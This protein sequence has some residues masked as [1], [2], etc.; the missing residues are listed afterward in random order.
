MLVRKPRRVEGCII[1]MLKTPFCVGCN[2]WG[3]NKSQK[4]KNKKKKTIYNFNSLFISSFDLLPPK[5]KKK[6]IN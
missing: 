6:Y 3:L 4:I 1:A 5:K 2:L